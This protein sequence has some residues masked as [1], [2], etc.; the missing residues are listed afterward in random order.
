IEVDRFGNVLSRSGNASRHTTRKKVVNGST[1]FA[2]VPGHYYT[3]NYFSPVITEYDGTGT[4]VGSYTAPPAFDDVRGL[5]FGPD[6]LLYIVAD[7]SSGTAV[8]ALASSGT[9]QMTYTGP[10]TVCCN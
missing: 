5:V 2:F 9:V 10:V 1:S 7:G 3:S 4:V 6:N 8:L